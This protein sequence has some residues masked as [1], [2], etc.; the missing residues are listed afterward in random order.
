MSPVGVS[1][2]SVSMAWFKCF[3]AGHNFP[4][5][6]VGK[7]RPVGFYTTCFV[8]AHSRE[9]AEAEVVKALKRDDRIKLSTDL[10]ASSDARIVVEEIEEVDEADIPERPEGLVWYVPDAH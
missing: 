6:S 3:V 7:T 9:Q 2:S 5:E 4:G 10:A 8:K 1:R